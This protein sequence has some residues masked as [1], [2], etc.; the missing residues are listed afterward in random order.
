MWL[1]YGS[2]RLASPGCGEPV[3]VTLPESAEV[4]VMPGCR[5]TFRG[6]AA[7]TRQWLKERTR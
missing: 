3:A 6:L 7:R 4:A 2:G 5:L 1:D